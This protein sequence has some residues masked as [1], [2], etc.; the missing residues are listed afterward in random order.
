[1]LVIVYCMTCVCDAV[2]LY[3]T[4]LFDM[5]IFYCMLICIDAYRA[6]LLCLFCRYEVFWTRGSG[7]RK[8]RR[9]MFRRGRFTLNDARNVSMVNRVFA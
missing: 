2:M 8:A 6:G 5:L 3:G 9:N 7:L 4:K 1:M